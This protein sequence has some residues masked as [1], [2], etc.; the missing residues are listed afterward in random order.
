MATGLFITR[1]DLARNTI[2]NG[3][4][5]TDKFIQFI[6]IA[7][8]MHI[9]NYLGSA[10]YNRIEQDVIDDTLTGDYLTLVK[11]YIQPMLIHF[12]MVDYLPFASYEVK[13]GGLFKHRSETSESVTKEEM[14]FL[15]Q[16]HRNFA[17]FYTRRFIDYMAFNSQLK[18]P[19][20]WNNNNDDMYPDRDANFV[21]WVL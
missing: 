3:N 20:Y 14:D 2:I 11:D 10:L 13:N 9:Q 15:V 21:G 5:D 17:D 1:T 8:Q 19:E 12:A 4:V 7:Q 6:K 16:K 18:F